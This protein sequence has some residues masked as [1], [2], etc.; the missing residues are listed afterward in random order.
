MASGIVLLLSE[1]PA[2]AFRGYARQQ[3]PLS[4][5][6]VVSG[7]PAMSMAPS[8]VCTPQSMHTTCDASRSGLPERV[9]L[10]HAGPR[11]RSTAIVLQRA[12][13]LHE[14]SS[15][16][17]CSVPLDPTDCLS[18]CPNVGLPLSASCK[19]SLSSQFEQLTSQEVASSRPVSNLQ[20]EN[21]PKS[22]PYHRCSPFLTTNK[23]LGNW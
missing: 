21:R 3:P 19:A 12:Q 15:V 17:D 23:T 11:G 8:R 22:N 14:S 4:C 5:F 16:P 1:M 7:S 2:C 13:F 20:C 10:D 6:G 9:H 18:S